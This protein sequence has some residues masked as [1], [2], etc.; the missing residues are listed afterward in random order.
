M[1]EGG[2]NLFDEK[3]EGNERRQEL[4]VADVLNVEL[5]LVVVVV[6]GTVN[7]MGWKDAEA[8]G[9]GRRAEICGCRERG[10]EGVS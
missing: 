8:G 1:V 5:L 4:E 3:R 10:H 6:G 7:I 9:P 2:L